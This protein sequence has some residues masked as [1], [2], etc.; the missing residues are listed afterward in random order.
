MRARYGHDLLPD[1]DLELHAGGDALR[2][3]HLHELGF[4]LRG[5]GHQW[6]VLFALVLRVIVGTD[7]ET[8]SHVARW[9]GGAEVG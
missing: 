4:L 7:T 6:A 3:L 9:M 2:H 5:T 8:Y 1:L